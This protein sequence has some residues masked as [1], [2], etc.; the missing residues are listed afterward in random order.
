M[1]ETKP[2]HEENRNGNPSMSCVLELQFLDPTKQVQPYL[3]F[4]YPLPFFSLTLGDDWN[5]TSE[6]KLG[7]YACMCTCTYIYVG[8]NV[9]LHIHLKLWLVSA[10]HGY[11]PTTHIPGARAPLLLSN[12]SSHRLSSPLYLL[13]LFLKCSLLHCPQAWHPKAAP[14]SLL[15][16]LISVVIPFWW[17]SRQIGEKGG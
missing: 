3:I 5:F 14:L 13:P 16:L 1:H 17:S 12:P 10:D 11:S 2:N 8:K 4:G 7:Y 6:D 15:T 9:P